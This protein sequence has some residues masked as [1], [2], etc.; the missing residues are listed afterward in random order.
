MQRKVT[1]QPPVPQLSSTHAFKAISVSNGALNKN[2]FSYDLKSLNS[3]KSLQ[4]LVH[5]YLRPDKLF[6]FSAS[7]IMQTCKTFA[8]SET[9]E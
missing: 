8:S 2:N 6:K 5:H 7:S 9:V 1:A 4:S 3:F